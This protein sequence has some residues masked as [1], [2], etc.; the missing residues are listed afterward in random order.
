MTVL[1]TDRGYPTSDRGVYCSDLTFIDDGNPDVVSGHLI[2]FY[3]RTLM[4]KIIKQIEVYQQIPYNL[5]PV[6]EIQ[7][8]L[9]SCPIL[10]EEP[11]FDQSLLIEPRN[12]K[13]TDLL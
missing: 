10:E 13:K 7:D 1:G 5:T 4:F 11:L 9:K 8:W 2:N 12:A 3:K 6:P